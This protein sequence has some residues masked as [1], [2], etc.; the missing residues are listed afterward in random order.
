VKND[1][2]RGWGVGAAMTLAPLPAAREMEYRVS[3][4]QSSEMGFNVYLRLVFQKLCYVDHYC[5][6]NNGEQS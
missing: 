2:V 5:W 3:V 6:S 1:G 4:L